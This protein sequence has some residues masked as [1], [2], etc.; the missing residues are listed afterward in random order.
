MKTCETSSMV[1]I[2]TQCFIRMSNFL[3]VSL[4]N[5]LFEC[6]YVYD[7]VAGSFQIRGRS[8][9]D[10]QKGPHFQKIPGCDQNL[11]NSAGTL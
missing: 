2:N 7:A 1:Q 10:M 4:L 3:I 8:S 11:H 6:E 9:Q 5:S